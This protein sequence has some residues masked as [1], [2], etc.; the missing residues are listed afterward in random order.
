MPPS[1]P[2]TSE[3]A[4]PRARKNGNGAAVD[5][6]CAKERSVA[7][8][9]GRKGVVWIRQETR[10]L[11]VVRRLIAQGRRQGYVTLEVLNETLEREVPDSES[12]L[13]GA[14]AIQMVAS[15]VC[16]AG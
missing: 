9:N 1:S 8:V 4:T 7:K 12:V 11:E 13:A 10:E 3:T 14:E 6:E 5:L 15:A 2:R 16:A